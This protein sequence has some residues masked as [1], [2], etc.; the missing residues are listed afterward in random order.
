MRRFLLVVV[1]LVGVLA[2]AD[3]VAAFAA[4]RVVAER[5]QT[6][7]Q[8]AVRPDVNIAGFPFLT[9][10][11]SGHYDHVDVAVHDLQRGP[12]HI[13]QAV[14]HLYDVRLPFS[15]VVHQHVDRIVVSHATAEIDLDYAD[16]NKALA[17][18]HLQLSRG[19]GGRVHVTAGGSAAGIAVHV[20][21]D[22]PLSV[23]GSALVIALPGGLNAQI[24][25][26]GMPFGI[27]LVSAR[28]ESDGIVV[29]CSTSA[30]V[31]RP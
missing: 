8:L 20:D 18:K 24:P 15:A 4:E 27:K 10:M 12:L 11:F 31:L 28:A 13:S 1:L 26:P 30:F 7:E 25:L 3:R 29:R 19:S 14:A 5:I 2:I 17:S 6:D 21:G 23:E 16:V 9:Q 22:F